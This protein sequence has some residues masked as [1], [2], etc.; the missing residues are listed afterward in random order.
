ME[1]SSNAFSLY[2]KLQINFITQRQEVSLGRVRRGSLA[3]REDGGENRGLDRLKDLGSPGGAII[4]LC[5]NGHLCDPPVDADRGG[6]Q[7]YYTKWLSGSEEPGRKVLFY[8]WVLRIACPPFS[9]SFHIDFL[10]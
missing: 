8:I 3:T 9:L 1:L 5:V 2:M 7:C 4:T 10:S 6:Y